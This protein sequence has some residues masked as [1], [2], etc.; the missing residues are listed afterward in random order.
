MRVATVFF[1]ARRRD[2]L[3]AVA[4]GLARGIEMQ[5]H[6]VDLIE[7]RRDS[8]VKLSA[9]QYIAIGAEQ[10]GLFGGKIPPHVTEFLQQAGAV[11]GKKS[12]AFLLPGPVASTKALANL[13]RAMEHEGMFIRFSEVV[14][15]AGEAE[16]VGKSL[17][18]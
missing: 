3:S 4:Q 16:T 8:D 17:Q 14:K 1:P 11:S 18:I 13:M 7:A 2:R 12:F 6:Q 15:S 9:Y 5:G 10:T